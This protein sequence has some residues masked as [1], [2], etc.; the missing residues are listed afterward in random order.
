MWVYSCI[1]VC[2]Y[3]A[4]LGCVLPNNNTRS[5]SIGVSSSVWESPAPCLLSTGAISCD[6]CGFSELPSNTSD[7]AAN[8]VRCAQFK[9]SHHCRA[10]PSPRFLL[11]LYSAVPQPSFS[12]PS[13][14]C[15]LHSHSYS[16]YHFA[17]YLLSWWNQRNSRPQDLFS[18]WFPLLCCCCR[19]RR[20]VVN[21][22]FSFTDLSCNILCV[23]HYRHLATTCRGLAGALS[24]LQSPRPC[25]EAIERFDCWV[26]LF[27]AKKAGWKSSDFQVGWTHRALC[28]LCGEHCVD[29]VTSLVVPVKRRLHSEHF[30]KGAKVQPEEKKR[31]LQIMYESCVAQYSKIR[32]SMLGELQWCLPCPTGIKIDLVA[33]H[34]VLLKVP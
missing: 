15:C 7:G 20:F 9:D 17:L 11:R 31:Q 32:V 25:G 29:V 19:S 30:G 1:R 28:C 5:S 14:L 18:C 8:G 13:L 10:L 33:V 24:C 12:A 2:E 6:C 23:L 3:T 34:K 21:P 4:A 22:A 27:T 16:H 26:C